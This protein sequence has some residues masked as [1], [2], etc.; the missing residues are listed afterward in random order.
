MEPRPNDFIVHDIIRP[1]TLT[2]FQGAPGSMKTWAALDLLRATSTGAKWLGTFPVDQVASLGIFLDSAPEDLDG[3]WRRLTQAQEESYAQEALAEQK[4]QDEEEF[5]SA[6]GDLEG[7]QPFPV[8]EAYYSPFNDLVKFWWPESPHIYAPDPMNSRIPKRNDEMVAQLCFYLRETVHRI[9]T[10]DTQPAPE[11]LLQRDGGLADWLTWKALGTPIG[12]QL[13]VVDSLSKVHSLDENSNTEMEYM[14]NFFQK[15]ARSTGIAVVLLHHWGKGNE[16]DGTVYSGRGASRVPDG[17]DTLI[18]FIGQTGEDKSKLVFIKVRG[19]RP[20]D[21]FIELVTEGDHDKDTE[22]LLSIQAQIIAA[23]RRNTPLVLDPMK[24][25]FA[26]ASINPAVVG[27]NATEQLFRYIGQTPDGRINVELGREWAREF[28]GLSD[29]EDATKKADGYYKNR[30]GELSKDGLVVATGK[31]GE[32]ELT[33]K[34]R[35]RLGI[36]TTTDTTFAGT[37]GWQELAGETVDAKG[38]TD[39]SE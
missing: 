24:H 1:G 13:L 39:D 12:M 4:L 28:L 17:A 18:N 27:P 26:R 23:R 10:R 37:A 25:K 8:D 34:G 36:L 15:L 5:E 16:G 6:P 2:I 31:R 29:T 7:E 35:T 11:E 32:Y 14:V 3:Q 20:K 38:G 9:P 21:F 22:Y 33:S 30:R 19:K